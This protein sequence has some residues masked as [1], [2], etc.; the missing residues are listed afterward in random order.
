MF[1]ESGLADLP[2]PSRQSF[3]IILLLDPLQ[4]MS[5]FTRHLVIL[6]IV[7]ILKI[8]APTC[9]SPNALLSNRDTGL[10]IGLNNIYLT[11]EEHV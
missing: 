3:R 9:Y 11:F 10:L 5:K 4:L 8:L 2:F 7:N 6:F 1:S